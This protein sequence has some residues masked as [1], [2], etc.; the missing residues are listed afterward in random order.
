MRRDSERFKHPKSWLA[1][2]QAGKELDMTRQA[3]LKIV[4]ALTVLALTAMF[5]TS[6]WAKSPAYQMNGRNGSI[7]QVSVSVLTAEADA[8]ASFAALTSGKRWI[9]KGKGRGHARLFR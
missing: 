9:T 3:N 2:H 7:D 1:Q 4:S 8:T 5:A 6:A